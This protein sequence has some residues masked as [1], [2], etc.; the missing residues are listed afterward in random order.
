MIPNHPLALGPQRR[1]KCSARLDYAAVL[2]HPAPPK[3]IY[4]IFLSISG[5]TNR[6][7]SKCS[8]SLVQNPR[9]MRE[10]S[11]SHWQR[12]RF[13]SSS[14]ARYH[15]KAPRRLC[16]I[17]RSRNCLSSYSPTVKRYMKVITYSN[18]LK[19]SILRTT[20]SCPKAP[21]A[22]TLHSSPSKLKS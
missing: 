14:S 1:R 4:I 3:G 18:T 7:S 21:V 6:S 9:P 2:R 5:S 13:L 20:R 22:S 19:Q 15:E 8:N 12:K 11:G 17:I 16:D 10:K